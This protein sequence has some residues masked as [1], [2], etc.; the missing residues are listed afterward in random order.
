[1]IKAGGASLMA[2]SAEDF[3]LGFESSDD[4]ISHD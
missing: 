1:M 2:I 4:L 3:G